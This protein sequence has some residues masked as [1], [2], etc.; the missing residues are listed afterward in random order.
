MIKIIEF[1]HEKAYSHK[2]LKER[3]TEI[4]KKYDS[5]Q[6]ITLVD[7]S[8]LIKTCSCLLHKVEQEG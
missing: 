6:E 4:A 5:D 3:I 8:F 7:I 1:G 2:T